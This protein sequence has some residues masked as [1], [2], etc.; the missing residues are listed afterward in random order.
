MSLRRRCRSHEGVKNLVRQPGEL[1]LLGRVADRGIVVGA[2]GKGVKLG[3]VLDVELSL[4]DA[5]AVKDEYV[6]RSGPA[7]SL[8]IYVGTH[9]RPK[10][11]LWKTISVY[12][13][14]NT[15][16]WAGTCE[17]N[18]DKQYESQ[19][20]APGN[21]LTFSIRFLRKVSS[22]TVHHDG[23]PSAETRGVSPPPRR[24]LEAKV[25]PPQTYRLQK[26]HHDGPGRPGRVSS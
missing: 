5:S 20:T 15:R 19:R 7:M 6:G 8:A 13:S 18:S 4:L 9:G 23:R 2:W 21:K 16:L 1:K 17:R 11:L 12:T 14:K 26:R 24:R 25:G 3:R 22:R 10:Q